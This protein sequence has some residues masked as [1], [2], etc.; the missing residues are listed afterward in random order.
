MK[1]TTIKLQ[2]LNLYRFPEKS[3]ES[4]CICTK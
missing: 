2:T 1:D 3:N 4:Y